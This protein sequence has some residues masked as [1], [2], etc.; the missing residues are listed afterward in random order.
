MSNPAEPTTRLT[1]EE[2][3]VA[4][5]DGELDSSSTARVER[6]LAED[7]TY[8]QQLQQLQQSWD[9][10]DVLERP[11]PSESFTRDTV[12]MVALKTKEDLTRKKSQQSGKRMLVVSGSALAAALS[13]T[14]GFVL[15]RSAISRPNQKLVRDLPVIEK[16]DE[17]QSVD[18][19]EF[20]KSLQ[21]EGLFGE[22]INDAP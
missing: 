16:L 2:E 10:L 17:Y 3:L 14:L 8:R 4:Y 19:V 21:G 1:A 15:I 5:L 12:E 20:L 18:S 13:L 22:E 7:E 9:M 6:R 11:E